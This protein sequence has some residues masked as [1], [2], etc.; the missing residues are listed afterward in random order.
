MVWCV[1]AALPCANYHAAV[2]LG[3]V[4]FEFALTQLIGTVSCVT[5]GWLDRLTVFCLLG[6]TRMVPQP[7]GLSQVWCVWSVQCKGIETSWTYTEQD[8]RN[9]NQLPKCKVDN[10]FFNPILI[11]FRNRI[12]RAPYQAPSWGLATRR[13]PWNCWSSGVAWKISNSLTSCR[14]LN[15]IVSCV[16]LLWIDALSSAQ[17]VWKPDGFVRDFAFWNVSTCGWQGRLCCKDCLYLFFL[18]FVYC[19]YLLIFVCFED[20]WFQSWA[21]G[22]AGWR[23]H[24]QEILPSVDFAESREALEG[25]FCFFSMFAICFARTHWA[26]KHFLS[27]TPSFWDICFQTIS[28]WL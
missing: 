6:V 15:A 13:F 19:L 5:F 25:N 14:N 21:T 18:Y 12:T 26:Q 1:C 27:L 24:Q 23:F 2:A 20:L 8:L 7:F 9:Q 3:L 4:V 22:H 10:N 16:W 11:M 17:V 28:C